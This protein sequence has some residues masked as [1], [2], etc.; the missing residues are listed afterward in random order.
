MDAYFMQP[1][2]LAKAGFLTEQSAGIGM[3]GAIQV[4]SSVIRNIVGGMG[5]PQLLSVC[6]SVRKFM[7]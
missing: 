3:A 7:Q 2:K 6:K 5:A 4:I 1:P